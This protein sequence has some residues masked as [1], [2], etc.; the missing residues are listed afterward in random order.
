MS[1]VCH[2][3]SSG[4]SQSS[5]S[6]QEKLGSLA[7][8]IHAFEDG[9][10]E[11][12]PAPALLSQLTNELLVV[13]VDAVWAVAAAAKPELS[14][15]ARFRLLAWAV[16][17]ARGATLPLDKPLALTVGKRL[18]RQAIKTRADLAAVVDG[19]QAAREQAR[20]V[21]GRGCDGGPRQEALPGELATID[22]EEQRRLTAL[23]DEVYVGFNELESLLPT[24]DDD[25]PRVA[26]ESEVRFP[27]L[28]EKPEHYVAPMPADLVSALGPDGTQALWGWAA[29]YNGALL[30][31]ESDEWWS[32]KLPC[33]TNS[34]L[35]DAAAAPVSA[36]EHGYALEEVAIAQKA[37]RAADKRVAEFAANMDA[38]EESHEAEVARLQGELREA[39]GREEA[40]KSVIAQWMGAHGHTGVGTGA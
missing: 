1:S 35:R 19:A 10:F 30:P 40:L 39:N 2:A 7:R 23:H 21:A 33:F 8:R 36:R 37:E 18:E 25:A 3:F 6:L 12:S 28:L 16:A 32:C 13:A 22:Q 17:D 5:S 15:V 11:P 31:S 27:Y 26:D 20:E 9:S 4:A 38:M 29:R 14:G 34:L 24:A